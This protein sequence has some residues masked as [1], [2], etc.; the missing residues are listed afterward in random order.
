MMNRRELEQWLGGPDNAPG[1]T[2]LADILH[3]S[4]EGARASLTVANADALHGL[5][6]ALAVLRDVFPT[7]LDVRHWLTA[8][9]YE[10]DGAAPVELLAWGRVDELVE[11]AVSEWNR[12]RGM[13]PRAQVR[14]LAGVDTR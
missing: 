13:A 10:L 5:R 2:E 12:P 9:S 1:L 11:L 8:P 4:P 6:F 3:E 14:A 7:D